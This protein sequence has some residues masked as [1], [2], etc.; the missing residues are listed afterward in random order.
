MTSISVCM[1]VKN[2]EKNLP[3][4]LENVKLFADEIVVVDTGSSDDT[5]KIAEKYTNKIYDFEWCDDF[6]KARN[7][8]FSKASCDYMM[9]LDADDFI[10][11][12]SIEKI[13]KMKKKNKLTAD[14]YMCKYIASFDENFNPL[15][16]YY[17]ERILKRDK[18]F[19]WHDPVH[20]VI[21]PRG[22]IE[23]LDI[24][25]YHNKKDKPAS[26]RNLKIYQKLVNQ[27]VVLTP[28][29]RFYYARE[30]MYN[31]FLDEAIKQFSN[32]IID[33][34]GWIENKIEACLNLARC[35]A[36]KNENEHALTSLFGSF[37]MAQPRGEILCEIGNIFLR[38][39]KIDDAIF[40]YKLARQIKP[41]LKSGAFVVKD[42]YDFLP[43]LQLCVC[44]YKKNDLK[45][46]KIYHELA[47]KIHPMDR[48]VL[49]N[50]EF[51]NSL[52]TK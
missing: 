31:D 1:I 13:N 50:E 29:Q 15:F 43:C 12:E 39:D 5:K 45:Q 22:K 11:P 2:E 14:V 8:S 10:L 32:F 46:S 51:F 27:N 24:S 9:W 26:D 52:K 19:V 18:N 30:L 16:S 33:K 3:I 21:I 20:E 41:N 4:I 49:H 36:A 48:S 23:Y 37:A 35:Y 34:N 7:Y 17:R 44:Y 6:A 25:I 40:W 28:R 47:K 42:C 38:M